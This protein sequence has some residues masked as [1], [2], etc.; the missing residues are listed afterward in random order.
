MIDQPKTFAWSKESGATM[1]EFSLAIT[2]AMIFVAIIIDGGLALWNY[3]TVEQTV[4]RTS[5]Q[6]AAELAVDNYGGS[7]TA[8]GQRALVIFADTI[9]DD[10]QVKLTN[11][12]VAGFVLTTDQGTVTT[13][14]EMVGGYPM[15]RIQADWTLSCTFCYVYARLADPLLF[16]SISKSMIEDETYSCV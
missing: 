4:G 10:Y 7:C 14:L 9:Q 12:S 3:N 16:T 11:S 5:R 13:S 1:L 6:I 15:V 8:A 2:T